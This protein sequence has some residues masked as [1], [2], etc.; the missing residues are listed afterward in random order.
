[1]SK[2]LPLLHLLISKPVKLTKLP[3]LNAQNSPTSPHA[4]KCA[5][6]GTLTLPIL[7]RLGGLILQLP[8]MQFEG[9]GVMARI[10]WFR[11]RVKRGNKKGNK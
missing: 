9:V 8:P 1:M 5:R 4:T 2:P 10:Y 3:E 11:F 6:P 7:G